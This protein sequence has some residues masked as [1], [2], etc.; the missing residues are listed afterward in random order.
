MIR[1]IGALG[2]SLLCL[3]AIISCEKDFNDLGTSV[4]NN[5]KFETGEILLDVEI[6]PVDIESVRADNIELGRL[7]SLGTLGEYWLGV[8]NNPNTKGIQASIVS[9]VRL[10]SD[11]SFTN[12]KT[13][14]A[15][16]EVLPPVL[17][18]VILKIP[19]KATLDGKYDNKSPKFNLDNIL[20]DRTKKFT[21]NIYQNNTFLSLLNQVNTNKKNVYLSNQDYLKGTLLGSAPDFNLD[22]E[23]LTKDSVFYF[24]RTVQANP[25]RTF[26]DSIKVKVGNNTNSNPFKYI[27]LNKNFF[28]TNFIDKYEEADFQDQSAFNDKI[29]RGL[30]I[31]VIDQGND[32]A[33]VPLTFSGN[34][35]PSIDILLTSTVKNKDGVVIDSISKNHSYSLSGGISNSIYKM[36]TASTPVLANNFIIQGTAGSMAKIKVLD[37]TKLQELKT[38]NWLVNDA[39]LSF[40][41]NSNINTDK[42]I[43]PQ[44]LFLYQ[45][46]DNGSGDTSPTQLTDAY[47]EAAAFGGNLE[48]KDDNP[49]KYTFRITDYISDLLQGKNEATIDPLILKVYNN[50]TDIPSENTNTQSVENVKTYNWNP[51]GVTLLNGNETANGTKRAVL[52]ISYSKE[53]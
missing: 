42:N 22:F 25:I 9:Q 2:I 5:T 12:N 6:T 39:S 18:E 19:L 41:V 34:L 7:G 44:R 38:K 15:T 4:V 3:G 52:K 30:I 26:K 13:Y 20:G 10:A 28:Q 11:R 45:N 17:D 36:S 37:N 24:N 8:Y 29:L 47:K 43:V 21:I 48:L 46:K 49:E 31:E 53:K 51:R 32:G 16:D 33:A 1:K 50:P 35:S 27:K 40:Y 14:E 23:E